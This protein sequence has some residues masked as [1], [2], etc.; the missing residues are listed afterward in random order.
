MVVTTAMV[1]LSFRNE[2]SLSSASATRKSPRPSLALVPRAFRRPPMTMVGSSPPRARTVAT[3]EVVVVFPWV[4]A[5]ATPY[6]I[7]IS[8]ASISAR[9][10]TGIEALAGGRDL[11]VV[12]R[13]RGGAHHHVRRPDVLRAVAD[14]H[15]EPE[16]A[17]PPRRLRRPAVRA[18]DHV[19]E[20]VQDLGDAAHPDAADAHEVNPP[21]LLEHV[22]S[23]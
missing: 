21:D 2:P 23:V 15:R 17:Q 16:R 14:G 22:R 7:R 3:M 5:T 13:D 20:I 12:V 6:F 4:P 18:G 1:G 8:S 9:W 10:I 19:A 11:H